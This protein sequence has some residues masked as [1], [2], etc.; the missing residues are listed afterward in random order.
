MST[1][2]PKDAARMTLLAEVTGE[3]FGVVNA[4][5]SSCDWSTNRTTE[6][7]ARSALSAHHEHHHRTALDRRRTAQLVNSHRTITPEG[8]TA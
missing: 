3:R 5:C 8:R 7:Y 1:P 4:R 2:T 6:A